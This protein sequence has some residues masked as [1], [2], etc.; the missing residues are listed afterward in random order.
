MDNLVPLST[1]T[2]EVTITA[3]A[4]AQY[5]EN[6]PRRTQA[7]EQKDDDHGGAQQRVVDD[8]RAI[9]PVQMLRLA[10][11]IQQHGL[12]PWKPRIPGNDALRAAASVEY[13]NNDLTTP[14]GE[15]TAVAFSPNGTML[16]AGRG[17][18]SVVLW[19]EG[20]PLPGAP[21]F[22]GGREAP[23]MAQ[24]ARSDFR[25][26]GKGLVVGGCDHLVEP[27]P[28]SCNSGIQLWDV[29][30]PHS[31]PPR[32]VPGADEPISTLALSP[33]DRTLVAVGSTVRLWDLAELAKPPVR[34]LDEGVSAGA[35]S[36]DGKR[37]AGA[38]FGRLYLWDLSQPAR[39]PQ[40]VRCWD[41]A[42]NA[43]RCIPHVRSVP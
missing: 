37:L 6:A 34:L 7:A 33:D 8:F 36:P 22:L 25:Q 41:H 2:L 26:D 40:E 16:A 1:S 4:N 24:V 30:Q 3:A 29:S 38:K 42:T 23:L 9:R 35:F 17:D 20:Y 19:W 21:R 28:R 11:Q 13:P 14:G 15:I 31:G 32:A 12:L 10:L 43:S 39:A 5:V 18:G 27:Q